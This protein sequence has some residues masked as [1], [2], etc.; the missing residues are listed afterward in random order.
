MSHADPERRTAPP[1]PA[2]GPWVVTLGD[3]GEIGRNM[4]ALE[5]AGRLLVVDCGVPSPEEHQP[6]GFAAPRALDAHGHEVGLLDVV[7]AALE[8]SDPR[9]PTLL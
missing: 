8:S 9:T 2:G 6:G 1:L 7:R 4:T 5:H 3:L